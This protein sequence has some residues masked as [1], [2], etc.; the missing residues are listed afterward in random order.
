MIHESKNIVVSI[1]GKALTLEMDVKDEEL[2]D[3]VVG[4]LTQLVK[5]GSA[6]KVFQTYG[7]ALS[8]TSMTMVTKIIPTI[9]QM[10]EW[11]DDLRR[12]VRIHQGRI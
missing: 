3:A 9:K 1:D 8:S 2:I 12:V 10:Q 7:G 6:L 4:A 11:K 5:K